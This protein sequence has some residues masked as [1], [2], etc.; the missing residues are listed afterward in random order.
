MRLG[1]IGLQQSGRSTFFSAL[2]GARGQLLGHRGP[3]AE[4]RIATITVHDERVAFLSAH[5]SPKKTTYARLEY[6]L[7]SDVGGGEPVKGER[8]VFTQVRVCDGLVHVVRNFQLD[9]GQAPASEQ[10]FRLL[11]EELILADLAVVEKRIERIELDKKRGKR[12]EAEEESLLKACKETLEQGQPLRGDEKLALEPALKGFTLL[13]AKPLLVVINNADEDE[14]PPS[15]QRKPV[16]AEI[17]V[18]RGRLEMDIATMDPD[19]AQEFMVAYGLKASALDRVIAASFKLLNRI[20]FFTVGEDEVRAWPIAAGT[21]AMQAA[22][23]VHSDMQKGFIRAEV[24]SYGD[25]VRYGSFQEAKK[26]GRVR[27]EG[28]EYT[29]SDGDIINFRFN[30]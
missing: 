22:G 4:D 13:S 10:D 9:G 8:P 3:S 24:L 7:P 30:V 6:L 11:E 14:A 18:V 27:L 15:W 20:C 1:L 26:V 29:V 28:K 23:S 2:T 12:P 16:G 21:Q 19:E 5:Y 25:F 17:L